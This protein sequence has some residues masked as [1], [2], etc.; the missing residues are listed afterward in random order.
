M[1]GWESRGWGD[2]DVELDTSDREPSLGWTPQETATGHHANAADLEE[3]CDDEG[4]QSDTGIGDTDGMLEQ[5]SGV[6]NVGGYGASGFAKFA[7]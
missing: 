7:E 6:Q 5:L 2:I 1:C 4:D 3:Q